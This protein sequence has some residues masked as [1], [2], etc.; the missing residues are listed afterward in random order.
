MDPLSALSG[1]ITIAAF[2][3]QLASS[4]VALKSSFTSAPAELDMIRKELLSLEKIL[5][6]LER[7]ISSEG[8][9]STKQENDD[10]AEVLQRC[11]AML[12]RIQDKVSSVRSLMSRNS[13]ERI[14][15]GLTWAST[16]HD[17]RELLGQLESNKTAILMSLQLRNL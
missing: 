10:L 4:L 15:Q 14:M 2:A 12:D 1:A 13:L 3:N 17:L 16:R 11:K 6:Y 5:H 9:Q 7:L 8:S